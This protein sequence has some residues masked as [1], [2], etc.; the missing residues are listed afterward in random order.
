M[1]ALLVAAAFIATPAIAKTPCDDIAALLE[2]D[3]SFTRSATLRPLDVLTKQPSPVAELAKPS[4]AYDGEVGEDAY[5]A[6][7]AR[8]YGMDKALVAAIRAQANFG[9]DKI[10]S[11]ETSTVHAFSDMQGTADCESFVFFQ[12][13][14][15]LPDPPD[16]MWGG[17]TDDA[18][19]PVTECTLSDG[20]L[21]RIG[22]KVAF[23][24]TD[25]ETPYNSNLGLRVTTLGNGQWDAACRIYAQFETRYRVKAVYRPVG[26][27]LSD[28]A[29]RKN[30]PLIARER[31]RARPHPPAKRTEFVFGAKLAERDKTR[32]LALSRAHGAGIVDPIPTFGAKP[33]EDADIGNDRDDFPVM[34]AGKPYLVRLAHPSIGWRDFDGYSMIFFRAKADALEPVA[35]AIVDE[36]RGKLT[37]MTVSLLDQ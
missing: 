23:A 6:S 28:D 3:R 30:A 14:R 9:I 36:T 17:M 1:R 15:E 35:S 34:I 10:W 5:I 31:D 22:D 29:I 13:G 4:H 27:P 8:D 18:S 32:L 25:R 16:T 26:G 2:A 12:D 7:L 11:L 19:R 20:V 33:D 21:A 37:A 24:V